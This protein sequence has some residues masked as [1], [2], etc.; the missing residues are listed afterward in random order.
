MFT[1]KQQIRLNE[2]INY[3]KGY[4]KALKDG[5]KQ[6]SPLPCHGEYRRG[7]ME[8]MYKYNRSLKNDIEDMFGELTCQ[9]SKPR[10]N[11]KLIKREINSDTTSDSDESTESMEEN[12]VIPSTNFD[13]DTV[14]MP[15]LE[16]NP[17]SPPIFVFRGSE[18]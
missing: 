4:H 18:Q 6:T 11:I 14:E 12:T 13:S 8:G 15:N 2:L 17:I 5:N 10:K 7:Y 9:S 16:R 1:H 3:T